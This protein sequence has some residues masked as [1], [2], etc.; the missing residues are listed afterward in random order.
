VCRLVLHIRSRLRGKVALGPAVWG[1]RVQAQPLPH[2]DT[3][4][5]HFCIVVP[6]PQQTRMA[7]LNT[8]LSATPQQTRSSTVDSL[9]RDPSVAP[10]NESN[11]RPSSYSVLSPSASMNSDKENDGPPSRDNTPR[12]A[13]RGLR[14]ASARMPTPDSGS[15]G[16]GSGSKRRRTGTYSVGGGAIY[17]DE[18]EEEQDDVDED[19]EEERDGATDAPI[20]E[21]E[22]GPSRFYNPNQNPDTRRRVRANMRDHGRY[23][24][25]AC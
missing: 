18:P 14:G 21:E 20:E 17:Q 22:E 25:G 15:T 19:E 24:E 11:A 16:G 10:R 6:H 2:V 12:P 9:Y 1:N 23:V 7:R 5:A 4:P 13:K 8:H 3:A